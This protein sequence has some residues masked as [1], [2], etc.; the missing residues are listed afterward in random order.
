M[1]AGTSALFPL[2]TC[3]LEALLIHSLPCLPCLSSSRSQSCSWAPK[4]LQQWLSWH[5]GLSPRAAEVLACAL[6]G[7]CSMALTNRSFSSSL[8][9]ECAEAK[10]IQ[11]FISR[12]LSLYPIGVTKSWTLLEPLIGSSDK[13]KNL[14]NSKYDQTLLK[15]TDLFS[16][17]LFY[18]L[19]PT[20]FMLVKDKMSFCTNSNA[21]QGYLL[22]FNFIFYED[23]VVLRD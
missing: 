6:W 8:T 15:E 17:V 21:Y 4:Q 3:G 1:N 7:S 19:K 10:G 14:S 12:T 18:H 5:V 9:L 23:E 20:D 11:V 13:D 2:L 16:F 22:Y